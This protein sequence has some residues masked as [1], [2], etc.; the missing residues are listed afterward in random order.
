MFINVLLAHIHV[1]HVNALSSHR[2]MLKP[3]EP[4]TCESLYWS[5]KTGPLQEL[6][7]LLSTNPSLQSLNFKCIILNDVAG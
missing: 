4:D 3:L 7:S 2:R 5:L 1:H 6:L